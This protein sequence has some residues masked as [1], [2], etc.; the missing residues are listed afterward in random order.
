VYK[1]PLPLAN[2]A[3][4]PAP[5]RIPG[6]R[7]S[8][9]ARQPGRTDARQPGGQAA[10]TPTSPRVP[11]PL[12]LVCHL[13]S[14]TRASPARPTRPLHRGGGESGRPE[15]HPPDPPPPFPEAAAIL[16]A[17]RARQKPRQAGYGLSRLRACVL[18][19]RHPLRP[20]DA[21]E[22]A[23]SRIRL[24]TPSCLRPPS[25]PSSPPPFNQRA[26]RSNNAPGRPAPV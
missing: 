24:V 22:A 10:R 25:P 9:A 8:P 2:R 23:P 13:F 3:Q 1:A 12:C 14:E 6:A 5:P 20:S 11:A 7:F 17:R 16:S 19:A 26:P 21:A 4:K 18:L 15:H